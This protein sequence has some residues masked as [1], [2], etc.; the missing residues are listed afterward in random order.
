M[1]ERGREEE[2]ERY[3]REE[4]ERDIYWLIFT[5]F[6]SSHPSSSYRSSASLYWMEGKRGQERGRE[7]IFD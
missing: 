6:R 2:R 5:R 1:R 7:Q 3:E 4:R